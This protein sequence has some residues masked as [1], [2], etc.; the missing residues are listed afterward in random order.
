MSKK[1]LTA[2]QR[3][4]ENFK[5][6]AR[7]CSAFESWQRFIYILAYEIAFASGNLSIPFDKTAKTYKAEVEDDF[8]TYCACFEA[9]YEIVCENQFNDVLGSIFMQLGIGNEAGGQFFTPYHIAQVV[10]DAAKV[11]DKDGIIRVSEPSC[12]AGANAIAFCEACH[13]KGI[14]YQRKVLFECQDVSELTALM[15]YIQLSFLGAAA[16]IIVGDTLRQ[17]KRYELITPIMAYE[18][19]WVIRGICHEW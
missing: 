16:K 3:F 17:E 12:G 9:Y 8:E 7:K 2:M 14:D 10:A 6:I 19:C 11:E 1:K 5:Q 13:K 15:C 4:E 18:P